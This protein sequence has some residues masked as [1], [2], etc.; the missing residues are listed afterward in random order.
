MSTDI[1]NISSDDMITIEDLARS[2]LANDTDILIIQDT[3]NTKK[4]SFG[5]LRSSLIKDS[6]EPSNNRIWS[7]E[8][9]NTMMTK[10]DS[11]TNNTV[12]SLNK[13]VQNLQQHMII[14]SV[15][16]TEI[17]KI[18][19]SKADKTELKV[20]ST[21]I[22]NRRSIADKLTSKDFKCSTNGE[23]F[24]IEHL[25]DDILS[26][27]TGNTPVA[28]PSVPKGGWI[29]EDL[30]DSLITSSKLSKY[31]RYR[32]SITTGSVNL[33]TEDGLYLVGSNVT[34]VPMH[35]GDETEAK[36]LEVFRY[37]EDGKYIKQIFTYIDQQNRDITRPSSFERSG[38]VTKIHT[39]NFTSHFEVTEN[40]KVESDLLGA[41]YNNRGT[42]NSGN[43][44]DLNNSGNYLCNIGVSNLPTKNANYILSIQ[45]Y[46]TSVEYIAK[47]IGVSGAKEYTSFKYNDSSNMPVIIPWF[48][49][50]TSLKSKFD[51]MNV[52][53]FGDGIIYGLGS[54]I[55]NSTSIPSIL[56]SKYGYTIHNHA[57]PDSTFGIYDNDIFKEKS[58]ITQVQ[59]ATQLDKADYAIIL[60]GVNDFKSGSAIISSNEVVNDTSFKG[61][62]N[63]SIKTLLEINPSIKILLVTPFYQSSISVGDNNNTDT[64]MINNK[65]LLDYANAIIEV[66][67]YNHIPSLNL[68]EQSMINKYTSSKYLNDTGI[69]LNDTGH[70]LIA[71]KIHSA[72]CNYY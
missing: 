67:K 44:Y 49:T 12:G 70:F 14:D 37:G 64:T 8:K 61:S 63:K 11:D 27:I 57:L 17:A 4:I 65:Y 13:K 9:I 18:E 1:T 69:Y 34:G 2:T 7:S 38:E 22:E 20:V 31:Y 71:D 66:G 48:S 59:L 36:L 42:L 52:H 58:V 21:E 68:Y 43:V 23:K 40:N 54:S 39:I 33:I 29:T 16:Q 26:A 30:S 24:H 45:S 60:C 32:G 19:L 56:S 62:I 10:L 25:G 51:G 3:E 41:T 72:M 50:G 28:I 5:D 15:L 6:L 53:I 55:I 35:S 46:G 47:S